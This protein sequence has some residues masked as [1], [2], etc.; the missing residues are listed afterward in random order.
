MTTSWRLMNMSVA[1][2]KPR[3]I[4]YEHWGTSDRASQ[5]KTQRVLLSLWCRQGSTTAT[6]CYMAHLHQ[7]LRDYSAYRTHSL[8][9]WL[10][11]EDEITLRQYLLIFIGCQSM[12]A[13]STRSHYWHTRHWQHNNRLI[14]TNCFN[15]IGLLDSC[16]PVNTIVSM[17]APLKHCSLVELSVTLHQQFGTIFPQT[18]PINYP[19]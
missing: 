2:V 3:T 9:S 5:L 6:L 15:Y 7:T 14:C 4:K 12:L 10:P 11:L 1:Y 13:L 18:L 19:Q 16:A 8:V 17:T